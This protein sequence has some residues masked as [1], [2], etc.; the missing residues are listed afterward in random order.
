MR[1]LRRGRVMGPNTLLTVR[2]RKSGEMRTTPVALVE[3]D[4]R[5]WIIGTFGETNWVRNLRAAAEGVIEVGRRRENVQARELSHDEATEFFGTTL[6]PYV[7][8]IP[9][10]MGR[11]LLGV[12]G[13]GDIF[14][15]PARAATHR[16]VFELKTG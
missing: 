16:P 11:V 8:G 10:G 1:L 2:G 12:L 15:D 7:A 4:G 5:R 13:A 9:F 14:K 6:K 3:L